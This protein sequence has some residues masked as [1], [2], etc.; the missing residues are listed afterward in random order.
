MQPKDIITS[1]KSRA[2]KLRTTDKDHAKTLKRKGSCFAVVWYKNE[3]GKMDFYRLDEYQLLHMLKER[4]FT[5]ALVAVQVYFNP[6][7]FKG[8]GI[9]EHHYNSQMVRNVGAHKTFEVMETP[10]SANFFDMHERI[11][12]QGTYEE[13][14]QS[15]SQAHQVL[16]PDLVNKKVTR[17]V[18]SVTETQHHLIKVSV[19]K[20]LKL[21]EGLVGGK[22]YQATFV[23]Y[24]NENWSP[25][26]VATKNITVQA[27]IATARILMYTGSDHAD[28]EHSLP[29][30]SPY[31]GGDKKKK[32][33][34]RKIVKGFRSL[35]HLSS[36]NAH[37]SA[38]SESVRSDSD[39][40]HSSDYFSDDDQRNVAL[41]SPVYGDGR[42]KPGAGGGGGG[43]RGSVMPKPT[44]SGFIPPPQPGL[45]ASTT[46]YAGGECTP[47]HRPKR[48]EGLAVRTTALQKILA[49]ATHNETKVQFTDTSERVVTHN[50]TVR[51]NSAKK[52]YMMNTE[53]SNLKIQAYKSEVCGKDPTSLRNRRPISAPHGTRKSSALLDYGGKD[54]FATADLRDGRF[55]GT[56]EGQLQHPQEQKTFRKKLLLQ[57]DT[58]FGDY[59]GILC[60]YL[61]EWEMDEALVK[62]KDMHGKEKLKSTKI[63]SQIPT[64]SIYLCRSEVAYSGYDIALQENLECLG[65]DR[66]DIL[67]SCA[68]N[69]IN[70]VNDKCRRE[71]LLPMLTMAQLKTT[72]VL[73]DMKEMMI[74]SFVY[75]NLVSIKST[76]SMKSIYSFVVACF[77]YLCASFPT[78][79]YNEALSKVHPSRFYYTAPVCEVCSDIYIA[80]DEARAKVIY[81]KPNL[82]KTSAPALRE[83]DTQSHTLGDADSSGS[84]EDRINRARE[85]LRKQAEINRA[86][87][88]TVAPEDHGNS[89]DGS[90][91]KKS[92][93]S[94]KIPWESNFMFEMNALQEGGVVLNT[95]GVSMEESMFLE[96]TDVMAEHLQQQSHSNEQQDTQQQQQQH[97][98]H[99]PQQHHHHKGDAQNR[100]PSERTLHKEALPDT[101]VVSQSLPLQEYQQSMTALLNPCL[102]KGEEVRPRDIRHGVLQSKSQQAIKPAATTIAANTFSSWANLLDTANHKGKRRKPIKGFKLRTSYKNNPAAEQKRKEVLEGRRL[103]R[104]HELWTSG[105]HNH[106]VQ[107]GV[108]TQT[109]TSRPKSA[110]ASRKKGSTR[111]PQSAGGVL[112]RQATS[113]SRAP[114]HN[115]GHDNGHGS[116]QQHGR[117]RN[118][119]ND[120]DHDHDHPFIFDQQERNDPHL[121]YFTSPAKDKAQGKGKGKCFELETPED[122]QEFNDIKVDILKHRGLHSVP[123]RQ[124]PTQVLCGGEF[125]QVVLA[126]PSVEEGSSHV[127][128]QVLPPHEEEEGRGGSV[129][130][131]ASS[132][133]LLDTTSSAPF[134]PLMYSEPTSTPAATATATTTDE[135]KQERD[136]HQ[137]GAS[138]DPQQQPQ[139]QQQYLHHHQQQESAGDVQQFV[140]ELL[141]HSPMS[142]QNINYS[143][144][145]NTQISNEVKKMIDELGAEN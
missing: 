38:R 74:A 108:R 86:E 28:T 133:N 118:Q 34:D 129:S 66:V 87:R 137:G 18:I 44:D 94:S 122:V 6:M 76:S 11:I 85:N 58:C 36:A 109:A 139:Q 110:T 47:D 4:I 115:Y 22:I 120:L 81:R 95:A 31:I 138:V 119:Y 93:D 35:K 97:Q 64:K 30:S 103:D 116:G 26:I 82:H 106:H 65:H 140:S 7:P 51:G 99:H 57:K 55:K 61:E 27:T 68:N 14:T 98:Q 89:E 5:Q 121:D 72:K 48:R 126:P 1:L 144:M 41:R 117:N 112:S 46:Q 69:H 37:N 114:V 130:A 128:P 42:K 53:Q 123:V 63:V 100:H 91:F 75:R 113:S 125:T 8:S 15:Q 83:L 73:P 23:F 13:F 54:P 25:F 40:D 141:K 127:S 104:Q 56:F 135:V 78:Q 101:G 60:K 102:G 71:A 90:G 145:Q 111:R 134:V 96:E 124:H 132:V 45:P 143:S 80:L 32:S 2:T 19:I 9:F 39:S 33:K 79:V 17:D 49:D 24:F 52:S 3:A 20:L 92:L 29:P 50:G 107:L 105:L 59:C 62:V 67:T 21:M 142:P 12:E 43:R 131:F 136:R 77:S 84:F 88:G 16:R 10:S 70:N